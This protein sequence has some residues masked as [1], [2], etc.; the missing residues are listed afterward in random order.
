MSCGVGLMFYGVTK[1]DL[2]SSIAGVFLLGSSMRDLNLIESR[3]RG[4]RLENRVDRLKS[5]YI[6]DKSLLAVEKY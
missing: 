5:L 2:E 1:S 3:Y 6:S 4:I